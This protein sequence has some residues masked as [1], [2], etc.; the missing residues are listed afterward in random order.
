LGLAQASAVA[1]IEEIQREAVVLRNSVKERDQAISQRTKTGDETQRVIDALRES[2]D[3]LVGERLTSIDPIL[4][5]IWTRIDPH[6]AFKVVRFLVDRYR[7]KG[8]L[9]TV[10]SDPAIEKSC[11]SPSMI[12]SSSQLNALAVA[13]FLSFNLGLPKPPL[14]V[15][16]LDDPLQSLDDINLLGLVDLLRRSKDGRQ[17]LVSTH[18]ARFGELLCRKL[19]PRDKNEKTIVIE[20]QEWS[21]SGPKIKI[22]DIWSDPVPLRLVS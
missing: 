14:P 5:D 19:R 11:E 22:R 1:T 7:G 20:L 2:M 18:D 4:Q 13:V 6:P 16:I 15:A 10:V 12:L 9:S 8:K 3:R 17:F 21:R